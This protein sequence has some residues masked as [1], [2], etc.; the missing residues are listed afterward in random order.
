M[1]FQN[2]IGNET[3]KKRISDLISS[4]RLPHAIILEGEEGIGKRTL[5]REIAS[6][7]VCRAEN[8]KPCYKCSQCVKAQKGIHPDIYEYSAPGGANSFHIETVRDVIKDVYISPNEADYKIYILA[9]AHCMNANAQN[10]ILKVLEEPPSYAVFILTVNNRAMLLETVLSRAVTVTVN[11]V[12]PAQGADYIV[13]QNP[14]TDYN[15][16]YNALCAFGGNI[17][18]ATDSIEGGYLQKITDI[19]NGIASGI[20]AN[21][22][23][24]LLK[25]LSVLGSNRQDIAAV[26]GMLKTVFRDALAGGTPL[27]GQ[28]ET[29]SMLVGKFTRQRIFELFNASQSLIEMANKNANGAL[30][31]TKICY[32]LREAAGR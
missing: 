5:A 28:S 14:K 6:A 18:R 26:L 31:I 7:L 22:E 20:A 15:V 16:A 8:D 12:D 11:G 29:V 21:D 2:F 4:S 13:A 24:E 10:A 3:V 1:N 32:T 9:N 25:T 23:Y 27:S 19:V 17:G 30:M